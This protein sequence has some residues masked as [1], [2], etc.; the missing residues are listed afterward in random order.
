MI[1]TSNVQGRKWINY[2]KPKS[3]IYDWTRINFDKHG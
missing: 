2:K 1:R 3:K